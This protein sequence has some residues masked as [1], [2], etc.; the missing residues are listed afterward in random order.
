MEKTMAK[1]RPDEINYEQFI[2]RKSVED[3]WRTDEK[4]QFISH[5]LQ[6]LKNYPEQL[7]K[8]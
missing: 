8:V 1:P 5:P 7:F 4:A 3:Y 6:I 2:V